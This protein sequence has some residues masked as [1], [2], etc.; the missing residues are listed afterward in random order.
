MKKVLFILLIVVAL[1]SSSLNAVV[2]QYQDWEWTGIVWVYTGSE[3]P[4]PLP[5]PDPDPDI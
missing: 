3:M 2:P 1:F 5:P 4:P